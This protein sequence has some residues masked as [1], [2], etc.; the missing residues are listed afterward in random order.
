MAEQDAYMLRKRLEQCG[1]P[2]VLQA[3]LDVLKE[4]NR[5]IENSLS[6]ETKLKMDL[7]SALGEAK[8][9]ISIKSCKLLISYNATYKSVY[10][11]K[12]WIKTH[13]SDILL[14]M[15]QM[16]CNP[17]IKRSRLSDKRLLKFWP[18]CQETEE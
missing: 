1:D 13:F 15:F 8:R 16:N 11:D 6:S 17:R 3:R 12:L 9:D 4:K 14:F 2:E 10:F 5:Q 7:F 18:S